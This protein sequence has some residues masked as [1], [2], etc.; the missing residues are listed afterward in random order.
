M[1]IFLFQAAENVLT[2]TMNRYPGLDNNQFRDIQIS[3]TVDV[4]FF[5]NGELQLFHSIHGL[6]RECNDCGIHIHEGTSCETDAD[7]GDHYWNPQT[8]SAGDPWTGE[9]G[10]FYNSY[11]SQSHSMRR[12]WREQISLFVFGVWI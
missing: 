6:E 3:G 8:V 9:Y 2:T 7:V 4:T 11:N 10:A 12:T 1:H 5:A